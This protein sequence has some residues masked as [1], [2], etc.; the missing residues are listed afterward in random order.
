[1]CLD[2]E[3][4]LQRDKAPFTRLLR[5]SNRFFN[6]IQSITRT[7]KHHHPDLINYIIHHN[8]TLIQMSYV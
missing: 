8:L 4:V 7:D 5:K 2:D 1:M 3:N 6:I